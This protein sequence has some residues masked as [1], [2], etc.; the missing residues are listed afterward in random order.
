MLCLQQVPHEERH[1][2]FGDDVLSQALANPD[3]LLF[4]RAVLPDLFH[5]AGKLSKETSEINTGLDNST[6]D[7]DDMIFTYYTDGSATQHPVLEAR[8][9]GWSLVATTAAD[10]QIATVSGMTPRP[11]PQTA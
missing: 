9:A 2:I 3:S 10:G 6:A 7:S 8:R 5:L 4:P 1:N 11:W